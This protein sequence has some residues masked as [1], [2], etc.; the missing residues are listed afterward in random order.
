M[1]ARTQIWISFMALVLTGS[2]AFGQVQNSKSRLNIGTEASTVQKSSVNGIKVVDNKVPGEIK[3]NKNAAIN[4]FYK[5][6]LLNNNN[7]KNIQPKTVAYSVP[8]RRA[9]EFL[10]DS[11]GVSVSNIYPNP[12][13]DY[14]NLNYKILEGSRSVKVSFINILGGSVGDFNLD[15]SDSR[16]QVSTRTWDNGIYFYQLMIDGKK[17]ATKKLVV[18]HQ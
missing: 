13:H 1:K 4:E 8:E 2:M 10:F 9:D 5:D 14:A 7:T 12:A 3:V 16:L 15:P 6:L 17:M 11:D 18:R